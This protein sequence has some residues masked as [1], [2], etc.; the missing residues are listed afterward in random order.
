M[1]TGWSL[2]Y[3]THCL[4]CIGWTSASFRVSIYS[5]TA[6]VAISI[7]PTTS[8]VVSSYWMAPGAAGQ[9]ETVRPSRA[10]AVP[11]PAILPIENLLERHSP[12]RSGDRKRISAAIV[13]S[14][15]KYEL[16]PFLVTSILLAESSGNPF[17]ISSG[18]TVGIMQIHVPTWASLIDSEGI[19]L[20]RVEDNV[21]LGTR[22]L[23]GYTD[24]YGLWLGVMRYLG[25]GELS[26]KAMED[27]RLVQGIYGK[28]S[29]IPRPEQNL[30]RVVIDAGH[31]GRDAGSTGPS[32]LK[33]KELVLDIANRLR[34]QYRVRT[35]SGSRLDPVR[36]RVRT[37]G[38]THRDRQSGASGSVRLHPCQFQQSPVDS[39]LRNLLP[40]PHDFAGSNGGRRPVRAGHPGSRYRLF[41]TESGTFCCG[42]RSPSR[43]N[44]RLTF[45]TRSLRRS[46]PAG[47]GASNPPLWPY[48]SAPKYPR[49]SPRLRSSA[50]RKTNDCS[51]AK[52]TVNRLPRPFLRG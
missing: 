47:T 7:L 44:S 3:L 31:G 49:F 50:T 42:T 23:K 25:A 20:F 4:V 18:A 30:G 38:N 14:A 43:G 51:K 39:R 13:T 2:K 17:A 32:G 40:Q 35:W 52:G 11:D 9:M 27:V 19:D 24:Q 16:D 15:R 5:A 29:P 34:N 21:D 1:F 48:W 46:R 6:A 8:A 41:G 36:R 12:L 22:V 26:E 45:R 28:G 33:E 10:M 37:A